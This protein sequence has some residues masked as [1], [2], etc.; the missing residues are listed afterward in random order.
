ML[1]SMTLSGKKLLSKNSGKIS[2]KPLTSI[3]N[4]GDIKE[5]SIFL[6][7]YYIGP[8]R[9]AGPRIKATSFQDAEKKALRLGVN[10]VG[11]LI[12]E[13]DNDPLGNS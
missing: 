13:I 4:I 12:A 3:K 2:H 5:E 8:M 9:M 7:E 6:T 10:I 1:R 11:K